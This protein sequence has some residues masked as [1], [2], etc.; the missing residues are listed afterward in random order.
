MFVLVA[1]AALAAEPVSAPAVPAP[2]AVEAVPAPV[3]AEGAA[4]AAEVKPEGEVVAPV[5]AEA[6]KAEEVK[7]EEVKAEESSFLMPIFGALGALLIAVGG[8]FV[9]KSKGAKK[10]E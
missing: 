4:P 7:A 2:V 3:A 1:A 8:W 6:P 5:I 9:M 10:A